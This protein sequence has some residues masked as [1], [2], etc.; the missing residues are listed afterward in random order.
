MPGPPPK[1]AEQRA[2]R[3]TPAGGEWTHAPGSGWQHGEI[4][5]PPDGL[6]DETKAEWRAWFSTWWS[7]FWT[8]DDLSMLRRMAKLLDEC[9]RIEAADWTEKIRPSPPY[10]EFRQMTLQFGMTPKARQTLRW[11]PPQEKPV[12]QDDEDEDWGHLRVVL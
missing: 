7:S 3:N 4:P 1:P 8:L 6:R 12:E 9:E 2:R 10:G 5:D 11:L